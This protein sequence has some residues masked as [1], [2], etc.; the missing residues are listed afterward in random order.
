MSNKKKELDPLEEA[1][2]K[3]QEEQIK[4]GITVVNK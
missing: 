3:K 4:K 2:K 1:M